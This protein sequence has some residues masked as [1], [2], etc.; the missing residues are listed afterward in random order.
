MRTRTQRFLAPFYAVF[1]S[2]YRQ[3]TGRVRAAIKDLVAKIF[4]FTKSG[5]PE[6]TSIPAC[7][8]SA[9]TPVANADETCENGKVETYEN[10]KVETC[11]NGKAET[12]ENERT[13][14]STAIDRCSTGLV[15]RLD[16]VRDRL[17]VLQEQDNQLSKFN[18]PELDALRNVVGKMYTQVTQLAYFS[19]PA[20]PSPEDGG[21][22]YAETLLEIKQ[23]IR[24]IKSVCLQPN[25][26]LFKSVDES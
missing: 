1:G 9:V 26:N 11:E 2:A 18:D 23:E 7:R 4:A 10:G 20:E 22:G 21:S 25:P 6:E 8:D 13:A 12:L 24:G 16:A 5:P 15:S 17:S 14:L 19:P 3:Y